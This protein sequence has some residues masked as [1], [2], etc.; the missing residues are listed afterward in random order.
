VS[1]NTISQADYDGFRQ[2]LEQACGIVLGDK[3]HYL[4]SSR[5]TPLMAEF[6][7][8]TLTALLEKLKADRP[9]SLRERVI[10]AMTTNETSWFR[11]PGV[12]DLLKKNILPEMS[13]NRTLPIN[14]W[15]AACSSGQEP[16]SISMAVQ[17]FLGSG[18]GL[19]RPGGEVQ[20]LATDISP[21]MLRQAANGRYDLAAMVRGLSEERKQ[22]FFIPHSV[23]WEVRPEIKK[24]VRFREMNLLKSYQGLGRFDIIFCR[25]VLIYFS[26]DIKRDILTRAT[27]LLNPGGYLFL[28]SAES[29]TSHSESFEM[30]RF[31]EG[32]VYR[33]KQKPSGQYG[34]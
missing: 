24:R 3:K 18:I 20:I 7:A 2:F 32:I 34:D 21:S 6:G 22:R 9:P 4:I 5:L 8:P 15:S 16:Y 12:F 30:L 27:A 19:G 14:L 31:P 11:D 13:K 29:L 26:Q 28:G 10:D 1:N 17:E 23:A 33:L 25:N